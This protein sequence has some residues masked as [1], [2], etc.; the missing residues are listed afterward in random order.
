MSCFDEKL[1]IKP[2][3]PHYNAATYVKANGLTL[4]DF[5]CWAHLEDLLGCE[6]GFNDYHIADSAIDGDMLDVERGDPDYMCILDAL[7]KSRKRGTAVY[8]VSIK[9]LE[10]DDDDIWTAAFSTGEK[11]DA[12]VEKAKQKLEAYGISS[13]QVCLDVSYLDDEMYLE[14]ID[15]R[16][17]DGEGAY[18]YNRR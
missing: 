12:F 5:D 18:E 13:V 17:G 4:L 6:I 1:N 10:G 7:I 8:T 9:D 14:W 2:G 15:E 11:A 3:E 16:Y